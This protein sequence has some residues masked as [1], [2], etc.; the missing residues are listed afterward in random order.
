MR[1]RRLFVVAYMCSGAAGLIYQIVWMRLLSL[2]LG[3]TVAAVGTVLAAY[4][5]GLAAGALIGGHLAP[6]LDRSGALRGY[7]ALECMI[8]LCALALPFG[9]H[10]F[11]PLLAWAYGDEPGLTFALVR[12]ASSLAL[13]FIP[14]AA[15]GITFPLAIR[16]FVGAASN[17]GRDA[18]GLYAL[19]TAGAAIGALVTG[20]VLIP[21][22]GLFATTFVG[23]VLNLTAAAGAWLIAKQPPIA[24]VAP[25]S[26]RRARTT[27]VARL[28]T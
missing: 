19:N 5:G 26:R 13:V 22:I 14:A 15:M 17:T 8:A 21:A 7:A 27:T 10:A 4:M 6:R 9:L 1:T 23:I 11:E 12:I 24:T 25:R 2:Q 3:H 28:P 20:F 18:G 16:W